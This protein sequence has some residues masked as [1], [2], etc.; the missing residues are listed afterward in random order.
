LLGDG[1][2]QA[3]GLIWH[4]DRQ[5]F[6]VVFFSL[7]VTLLATLLAT[8]LGLPLALLLHFR[9]FPGKTLCITLL[10]TLLSVP[11]VVV[12]LLV[13]AIL[14]RRGPAGELNLLFTPEAIIIGDI[15]LGLPIIT[16][17]GITA[18]QA[19]DLRARETALSLGA[20]PF[21][22]AFLLLLEARYALL[23]AIISAFSK[24]ISEVGC[25]IMVGGNIRGYTRTITTSIALETSKGEFAEAIALGMILFVI[26]LIINSILRYFQ[27][28]NSLWKS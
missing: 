12:G 1:F 15:L 13:Y 10:N 27:L 14:S 7:G 23:T 25:A 8:L 11:T 26:A 5:V 9:Q 17:L 22:L 18:L 28:K 16:A 24:I 20:G 6:A 4:A 19:V 3:L 21:S 2:A